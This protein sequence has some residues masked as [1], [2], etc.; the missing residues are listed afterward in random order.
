M[1]N[2]NSG[3]DLVNWSSKRNETDRLRHRPHIVN[4]A[5]TREDKNT[6]YFSSVDA[7]IYFGDYFIDEVVNIAWSVQQNAMPIYGYNSYTFDDIA[8]GSRIVQG[9]FAVNFTQANYLSNVLNSFVKISRKMYGPDNP[10]ESRFKDADKIRRNKPVWDAGFDI[11]IGY[12]EKSKDAYEQVMV[13]DCCQIT[14]CSQ[15]LD[16]NGEPVIEVYSFIARDMKFS[17]ISNSNAQQGGSNTS[18]DGVIAPTPITDPVV[19]LDK[20]DNANNIGYLDI[21]DSA[22]T[23]TV[24][25]KLLPNAGHSGTIVGAYITLKVPGADEFNLSKNMKT[26]DKEF[27]LDLSDPEK[28]QIKKYC[29][30]YE[31][32]EVQAYLQYAIAY[33]SNTVEK[34]RNIRVDINM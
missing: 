9:Q 34:N 14:G 32:K 15:Q 4:R 17:T 25:Y 18:T 28:N 20:N 16:Y 27:T 24:K 11:V 26:N 2:D 23:V 6:R 29:E 1:L 30:K 7:D 8:M 12:G 33:N 5:N 13:L 10:T 22:K 21:K 3:K 19:I 31:A